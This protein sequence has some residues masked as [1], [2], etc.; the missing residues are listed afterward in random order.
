MICADM[1]CLL[2]IKKKLLLT[3][4]KYTTHLIFHLLIDLLRTELK[5]YN[6]YEQNIVI[7]FGIVLAAI[8]E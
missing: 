6:V 1:L 7:L 2:G 3:M 4:L 8:K 5:I